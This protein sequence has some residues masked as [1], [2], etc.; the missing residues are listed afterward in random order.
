MLV[1][2]PTLSPV[3]SAAWRSICA[4]RFS[5]GSL[6]SNSLAMVTPSLQTIGE[7]QLFWIRTDLDFGPR[8][9][10]T[11]SQSS[12]APCRIFSR[13]AARNRIFLC[14]TEPPP[15]SPPLLPCSRHDPFG[16]PHGQTES[17][18][19][20]EFAGYP[21]DQESFSLTSIPHPGATNINAGQ[22]GANTQT[23]RWRRGRADCRQTVD[24][25][26]CPGRPIHPDF[27]KVGTTNRGKHCP[28]GHQVIQSWRGL[29]R[30]S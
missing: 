27:P 18:Q 17:R 8:V 26:Q 11:A 29:T 12:V 15:A 6:R 7:P 9:T 5:A 30:R 19:T 3:R 25:D 10:R 1:P 13:A 16:P 28:S 14:A 4:P 23:W 22:Q 20:G 24:P 2:S 21:I